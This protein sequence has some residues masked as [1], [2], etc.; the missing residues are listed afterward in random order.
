MDDEAPSSFLDAAFSMELLRDPVMCAD[1]QT[2]ERENIARWFASGNRT[3]PLTGALLDHTALTPNIALR[4]AIEEWRVQRFKV[5]QRSDFQIGEQIARGSFKVVHRATLRGQPVAAAMMRSGCEEEAVK[6]V[7][8]G[9][10]PSL[11]RYMGLCTDT[12][13]A[14]WP[15]ILFTELAVHGS[16]DLFLE[17]REAEVTLGHKTSMVEQIAAG[18]EALANAGLT[19]CDLA[20]RNVLVFAFDAGSVRVK[21]TDFG[22][23][24]QR[25]YQTHAYGAEG[26]PAPFR[27]MPP[28]ALRR[29]RFSEKSDVWAWGVTAWE[30]LMGGDIPYSHLSTNEQV[31]L[32]V[33]GG[34]RLPRPAECPDRLWAVIERSW[35]AA[36]GDRP[37]FAAIRAELAG[38]GPMASAASAPSAPPRSAAAP[39]RPAASL[40]FA[41]WRRRRLDPLP[42]GHPLKISLRD[43][44]ATG[45][46]YLSNKDI[47]DEGAAIVGEYLAY[48]TTL[49][50]LE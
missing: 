38:A 40:T 42:N 12:G 19:H 43:N 45:T 15:Q 6:L 9:R 48:N 20:T 16:L 32:A 10:H 35:A 39:L 37:D 3:S 50:N 14:E 24:V 18:M 2:Y 34:E 31:H 13:D 49:T 8:L 21:V 26:A 11:V 28:E 47:G 4:N 27:W 23:S 36:P 29:R 41:E 30:L 46:L 1:G 5:V 44:L 7:S 17:A 22:L 25:H 33:T